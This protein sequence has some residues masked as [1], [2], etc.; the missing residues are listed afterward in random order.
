MSYDPL[1][2]AALE[3]S[4]SLLA[5]CGAGLESSVSASSLEDELFSPLHGISEGAPLGSRRTAAPSPAAELGTIE[6][7]GG[8]EV[9]S[10]FA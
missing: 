10:W 9:A 1:H 3:R 8:Q 7:T 5:G 4:S 6:Q 2:P